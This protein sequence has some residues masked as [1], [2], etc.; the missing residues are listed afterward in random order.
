MVTL[1]WTCSL[2]CLNNVFLHLQ[3]HLTSNLISNSLAGAFNLLAGWTFVGDNPVYPLQ[4]SLI[5]NLKLFNT[6]YIY[7]IQHFES[8]NNSIQHFEVWIYSIQHFE[9][10]NIFPS[11][12]WICVSRP[13]PYLEC[14]CPTHCVLIHSSI[15]QRRGQGRLGERGMTTVKFSFR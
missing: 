11:S 14:V 13:D 5:P 12:L 6:L 4:C 7:S 1:I 9:S 10:M 3:L 2:F 15:K 8:M